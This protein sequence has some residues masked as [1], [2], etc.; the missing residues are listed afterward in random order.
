MYGED[1]SCL[2]W[3]IDKGEIKIKQTAED[4]SSSSSNKRKQKET[5]VVETF[6][7]RGDSWNRGGYKDALLDAL[8]HL[9]MSNTTPTTPTTPND[10]GG[11]SAHHQ[12]D[13]AGLPEHRCSATEG[14]RDALV[15]RAMQHSRTARDT[16]PLL[17]P[18][19]LQ[20]LHCPI[21]DVNKSHAHTPHWVARCRSTQHVMQ[22]VEWS[23]Q[24]QILARA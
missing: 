12:H 15:L 7:V 22:A 24:K 13:E 9:H 11:T 23:N 6:M 4:S 18:P 17:H 20:R 19:L 2:E 21:Y 14:I 1:N 3:N 8:R 5:I 10:I 16:V